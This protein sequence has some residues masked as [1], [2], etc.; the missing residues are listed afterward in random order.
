MYELDEKKLLEFIERLKGEQQIE[1]EELPFFSYS[2][3]IFHKHE[4]CYFC[5]FTGNIRGE[6]RYIYSPLCLDDE[7][8]EEE[9][10]KVAILFCG[11]CQEKIED[12]DVLNMNFE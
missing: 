10:M 4:S 8:T 5:G 12:K 7:A 9:V 11:K 3:D 6:G 2:R 1:D